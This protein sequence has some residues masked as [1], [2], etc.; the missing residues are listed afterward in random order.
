[1]EVGPGRDQG[2][3]LPRQRVTVTTYNLNFLYY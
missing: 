1:M 2:H 3:G